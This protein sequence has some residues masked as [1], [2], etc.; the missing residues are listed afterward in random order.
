VGIFHFRAAL[1]TEVPVWM[2]L[3][4]AE[5]SCSV[6]D[7]GIRG[8]CASGCPLAVALQGGTVKNV[9]H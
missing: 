2:S 7:L 9:N 4:A 5:M 3:I 6:H 8:L 1:I